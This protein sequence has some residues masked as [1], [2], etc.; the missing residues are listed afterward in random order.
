MDRIVQVLAGASGRIGLILGAITVA[1]LLRW[2]VP[3]FSW[4]DYQARAIFYLGV[5]ALAIATARLIILWLPSRTGQVSESAPTNQVF[6]WLQLGLL[7]VILGA[8]WSPL[9]LLFLVL[10]CLTTA[11]AVLENDEVFHLDRVAVATAFGLLTHTPRVSRK[12]EHGQKTP[13]SI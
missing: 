1:I 7:T 3:L 2:I 11:P 9:V 5:V 8:I 10:C 13:L 12:M 6:R 4:G